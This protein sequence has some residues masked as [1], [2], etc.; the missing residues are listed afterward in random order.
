MENFSKFFC[1]NPMQKNV[2]LNEMKIYYFTLTDLSV[3]PM[4]E[5]NHQITKF[6]F[7]YK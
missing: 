6:V 7:K 5:I 1:S 2:I 4:F 3:H